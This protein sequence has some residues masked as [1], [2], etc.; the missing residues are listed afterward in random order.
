MHNLIGNAIK[1]HDK[2]R[3]LIQIKITESDSRYY[4]EVE[5]DGP[6]IPEKYQKRIFK[7]FQTLKPR[8]Q[9]EGSGLGLSLIKKIIHSLDGEIN[10]ISNPETQ[11]G[12][13]FVFDWPKRKISST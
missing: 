9:V 8:D 13:R 3:G 7:L 5:D 10:V 4:F 12:S 11:R 2:E 6:G 1:H